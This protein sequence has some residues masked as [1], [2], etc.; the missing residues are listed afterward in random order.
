MSERDGL[1]YNHASLE[2]RFDGR[3]ER[4]LSKSHEK[5]P[6]STS[7]ALNQQAAGGAPRE[8]PVAGSP[9]EPRAIAAVDLYTPWRQHVSNYTRLGS[10]TL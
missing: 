3:A 8:S 7:Y 1:G 4:R 5:T 9:R 2:R 10:G 6:R